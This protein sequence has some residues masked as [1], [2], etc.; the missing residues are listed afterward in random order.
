MVAR[1]RGKKRK[2]ISDINDTKK[3][4]KKEFIPKRESDK[5]SSVFY[6]GHLPKYF[7]DNELMG[8]LKQFGHV[9]RMKIARSL[10]TGNC[11]GYAFVQMTTPKIANIVVDTLSGYMLF[12]KKL[13]CHM[14]PAS[15]IHNGMFH[16][17]KK[18]ARF[19]ETDIR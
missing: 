10:K 18:Y 1:K 4:K 3:S 17:K 16:S 5:I 15:Q 13:V 2:L 7:E 8:F 11:K 19:E 9:V 6:L 14:V 12:K